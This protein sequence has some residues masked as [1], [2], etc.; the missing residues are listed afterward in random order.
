MHAAQLV[1]CLSGQILRSYSTLSPR[2]R[3]GYRSTE[4]IQ[5]EHESLAVSLRILLANTLMLL[6]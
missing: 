5:L 3:F 2:V 1:R 6:A 4:E